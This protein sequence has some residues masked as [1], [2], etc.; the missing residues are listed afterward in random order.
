MAFYLSVLPYFQSY[1]LV[2]YDLSVTHAGLIVQIFTFSAT[3]T[4]IL[5]SIAIKYTRRYRI[6]VTA[7]ACL[8]VLG[9]ILMLYFR[10]QDAT[11]TAIMGAQL[12][13]GI[14]GGMCHGPAQLG[15]Q[16]SASHQ[17]VAA[18]TAAFLTLLEIGGAVGSAISGAIWSS[19][20][21]AKLEQY[22]PEETRNRS[23]EIYGSIGLAANGWPIGS[24]TRT[25]INLAYQ[26]TM[27]KILIVAVLVATPCIFLSFFMKDYKLD[28]I[29]Q[30]VK[31]VIIGGRHSSV[32]Y[33]EAGPSN[34]PTTRLL[35]DDERHYDD[36]DEDDDDDENFGSNA[37]GTH[38][39]KLQ[40]SRSTLRPVSRDS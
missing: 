4:S 10:T 19:N 32:D 35:Q 28:E 11:L 14:G 15:V 29:D 16:A 2:V 37:S 25:A 40:R 22:L 9:L 3:V 26:E 34:D 33:G 13:I 1:L 12:L 6:Y 17:E 18:A 21:P 27:T 30:Q 23:S 31:G 36:N 24:P 7:G 20:I 39:I 5:V 8:Y 38:S